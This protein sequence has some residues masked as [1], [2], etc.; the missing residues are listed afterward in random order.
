MLISLSCNTATSSSRPCNF[1]SDKR[2][3]ARLVDAVRRCVNLFRTSVASITT[4]ISV[5]EE[6]LVDERG[7][8]LSDSLRYDVVELLLIPSYF[9]SNVW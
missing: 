5:E 6:V 9:D 8:E 3:C 1:I 2:S 4:S 7:V